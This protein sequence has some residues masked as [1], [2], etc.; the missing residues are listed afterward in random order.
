MTTAKQSQENDELAAAIIKEQAELAATRGNW[1]SQWQEISERFWPNHSRLFQSGGQT[2]TEGDKRTEFIFD[3]TPCVA[4][5][6]FGSIMDSLLT[7]RN[8]TWHRVQASN[9]YL[10]EDRE[11]RLWFE[12]LNQLL[13]KIR[14]APKG[15]FA[16]QNNLNY[17]M[18]GAYGS[19]C[20]FIDQ[21]EGGRSEK[22]IRYRQMHLAGIYFRENHQGI[23]DS[24]H[25]IYRQKAR[26]AFQEWG[27]KLPDQVKEAAKKSPDREFSFIHCVKPR[28]DID[29][30]RG[31]YKAMAY[32]SYYVC[33]DGKCLLEESG[34]DTFPYAVSR[35]EQVPG[36]VYGR[37]PAMD[38][39]PAVKTLN[40]QMK[41][42]LKQG[43]RTVDPVLLAH[44]DGVLDTFSMRPGALNMGG[45]NSSGQPLVH[46]LPVGRVDIGKELMD[47][48]RAVIN[49]AFLV[50]LF[51]ILV[52][53]PQMTATEVLERTKEKGILIAPTIGRQQSEYLGPMIEREID[54]LVKLKLVAPMP[55][56]LLEA[57][58]EYRIEYESPMSRS[59]KAE[60]ATGF[61]R[62]IEMAMNVAQQ[63][64]NPAPLDHF[65]WDVIMPEV[66]DIQ[67]MPAKWRNDQKTIDG[68]R[69]GRAKAAEEQAAVAAAPGAAALTKSV[70]TARSLDRGGK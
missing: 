12:D 34:Y 5:N 48:Q 63:T 6:R 7:P 62:T 61:M 56:A 32:A 45:V 59:A 70:A 36:E 28:Q 44:D 33:I 23:V 58:G 68:I 8:Q 55:Q 3:S 30:A 21:L 31:D 15:N 49:D 66:A 35:Y 25:R 16:S 43:H 17:K 51:Q 37:A 54:L 24:V 1:E 9:P 13:F 18:L 46:A 26:N 4:L 53:S 29:Y 14:Y 67:G 47:D 2:P 60:E 11:T 41:T 64:Q 42:I 39:L 19:A 69:E 20:L 52:E 38:V 10:N 27:D 40:E 22:G 57:K 65:N 50:T